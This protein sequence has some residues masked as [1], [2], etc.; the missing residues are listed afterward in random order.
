MAS[1]LPKRMRLRRK[2]HIL[3]TLTNSKSAKKRSIIMDAFLLIYKLKLHLQTIKREPLSLLN[4]TQEEVKVE[5]MGAEFLVKVMCKKGQEVLV[6][7]LESFERM[8][9][10][11]LQAR[12]STHPFLSL[13]AIVE[14]RDQGFD[15][16]DVKHI[17]GSV[18]QAIISSSS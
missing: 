5:K 16:L 7:I 10:E 4:L 6:A 11:V 1:K 18:H 2:L 12:V 13:E 3:R 17:I 14:P 8:G 15:H 9:L